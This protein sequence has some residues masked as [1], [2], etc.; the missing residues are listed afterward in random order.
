MEHQ[1]IVDALVARDAG[2]GA[3]VIHRHSHRILGDT[4][5]L[6]AAYPDFFVA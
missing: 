3:D 4:V 1:Q 5:K 6:R 2:A